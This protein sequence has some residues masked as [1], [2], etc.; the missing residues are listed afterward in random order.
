MTGRYLNRRDL[1]A[2]GALDWDAALAD[3]HDALALLRARKAEMAA[4]NVLPLGTDP[5]AKGYGLPARVGGRFAAAGLK[6]TVHRPEAPQ[7]GEAITSRTVLD[8]LETGLPMGI[9]DSAMLTRVRTAALSG[10]VVRALKPGVR[11]IAILGA[12]AQAQMHLRMARA[13][14]PDLA[15]VHHWTRSGRAIEAPEGVAI[16]R[17]RA[18]SEASLAAEVTFA[19]T[20]APEPILGPEVMARGALILQIGY[21]EVSFDAIDRADAVTCDLWGDFARTSAKSLFQMHRAGRFPADRIAADAAAILLD[22]WRSDP[23]ACV[24]FSSFG[25][26]IFDIALAARLMR[27]ATDL[28][29]GQIL[30]D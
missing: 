18:A 5:R 4:E 25:L 16:R 21:H 13:V 24:Y 10:A 19:C 7:G 15:E 8:D 3:V 28:G 12:G 14:F 26:N 29:L 22:G 11:R 17:H 2:A 30:T 23:A 9:V 27:R 6:W 1:I 20:S